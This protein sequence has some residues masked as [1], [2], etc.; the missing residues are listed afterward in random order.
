ME[1]I[2]EFF[3]LG[4]FYPDAVVDDDASSI[5]SSPQLDFSSDEDEDPH[6][7]RKVVVHDDISETERADLE[8]HA[9]AI[10]AALSEEEKHGRGVNRSDGRALFT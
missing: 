8:R 1:N 9:D 4:I 6:H 7:Q 5:P 10:A 2:C 3:A